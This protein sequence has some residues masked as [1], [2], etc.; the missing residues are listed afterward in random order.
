MDRGGEMASDVPN[1]PRR[2]PITTWA[3]ER[4]VNLLSLDRVRFESV[5]L[6]DGRDGARRRM[7]PQ[8]AWEARRKHAPCAIPISPSWRMDCRYVRIEGEEQY[9]KRLW[10]LTAA[11]PRATSGDVS[12]AVICQDRPLLPLRWPPSGRKTENPEREFSQ[13]GCYLLPGEQYARDSKYALYLS[14]LLA[15]QGDPG[16]FFE[17]IRKEQ[18]NRRHGLLVSWL[19]VEYYRVPPGMR[20]S[21]LSAR[22]AAEDPS[23][24]GSS[25]SPDL[26]IAEYRIERANGKV[27]S[28]NR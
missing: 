6:I 20:S 9:V 10:E 28:A 14:S 1:V 11:N 19:H 16:R 25:D 15:G 5:P 21:L 2:I 26:A 24:F 12:A 18:A 4:D 27:S 17:E 22:R 7:S 3:S 23:S 13:R 8:L